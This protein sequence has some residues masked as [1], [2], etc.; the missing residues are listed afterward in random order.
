MSKSILLDPGHGGRDPGA[1]GNGL[2]EKDIVLEIYNYCSSELSKYDCDVRTTRSSDTFVSLAERSRMGN[3][4]DLMVSLHCNAFTNPSARGF[5]TF[6]SSGPLF[7]TTINYRSSIHDSI[8]EVIAS[9]GIPNRGKKRSTHYIVTVPKCPVTLVEYAFITN[10]TDAGFLRSDEVLQSF[11]KATAEGIVR[12]LGLKRKPVNKPDSGV[13]KVEVTASILNMRK[14]PDTKYPV[15]KGLSRGS[16]LDVIDTHNKWLSVI[17]GDRDS[18]WVHGDHT[19]PYK[20]DIPNYVSVAVGVLNLRKGPSATYPVIRGLHKGEVLEVVDIDGKWLKVVVGG[21][22]GWVHG[23][24]VVVTEGQIVNVREYYESL[25]WRLTSAYGW[26]VI[27]GR[28]NFHRGLDFGGYPC[29]HPIASPYPGRIVTART[30]GMGT[31]G[32]TVCTEL[33]NGYIMLHAHLQRINVRVG[34]QI[35]KG[36]IIGLNGGTNHSGASYPCHIHIEIQA[37]NGS[38]PWRGDHLDPEGFYLSVA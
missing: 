10:P 27:G 32:H 8:L 18:G 23:D 16:L 29:G 20:D 30:S 11:G 22:V 6:V 3:D 19:K 13:N 31:W 14:G 28:N 37:G 4:V 26:R 24:Y 5:E 33:S 21:I 7:A 34:Q 17:D 25:G 1:I 36:D 15:I 9:L 12:A 2:R 35:S 38:A